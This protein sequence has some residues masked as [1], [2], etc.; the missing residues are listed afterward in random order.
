MKRHSVTLIAD[1]AARL[2]IPPDCCRDWGVAEGEAVHVTGSLPSLGALQ[3]ADAP[4]MTRLE[5]PHWQ[6]EVQT[7]ACHAGVAVPPCTSTMLSP[8]S[9]EQLCAPASG[10]EHDDRPRTA[11]VPVT[12]DA[13]PISYNYM[14]VNRE[15][16]AS[17]EEGGP[18]TLQQPAGKLSES[19]PA[20]F[21]PAPPISHWMYGDPQ[22]ITASHR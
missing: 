8:G 19:R 22:L 18:R 16:Q 6:L 20:C 13:F 11:Q 17:V 15:G 21:P 7:R 2:S 4:R 12:A 9:P 1:R 5:G 14:V 3:Q 10:P